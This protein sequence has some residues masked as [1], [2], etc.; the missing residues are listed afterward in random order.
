MQGAINAL[1]WHLNLFNI[2]H[3]KLFDKK[4]YAMKTVIVPVDFSDTSLNAARY[5]AKLFVG[6]YGVTI[7]LYHS[8]S[9]P[10]EL[11]EAESKK[12]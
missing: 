2:C 12:S 4:M 8:Y 6:H 10:A 1:D 11:A 9:K 5:A 3:V 7:I